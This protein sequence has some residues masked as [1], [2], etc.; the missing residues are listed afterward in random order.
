MKASQALS[1]LVQHPAKVL[2]LPL[3]GFGDGSLK[4]GMQRCPVFVVQ[5]VRLVGQDAADG[6]QVDHLPLGKIG[7][8]VED[9][10][11]VLDV[12]FERH[13]PKCTSPLPPWRRRLSCSA[14]NKWPAKRLAWRS[15]H[16]SPS[17]MPPSTRLVREVARGY[18]SLVTHE[19][20]LARITI[21]PA[22]CHGKPC[23]R[24]QR[25][26]VGLVLGMLEGGMSEEEIL[27]DYPNLE[28]ADIRACLA[29]ASELT[30]VRFVDLPLGVS[31]RPHEVIP[32]S[33]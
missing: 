6:L 27:A 31:T 20:L 32:I 23:I 21:D 14:R 12:G 11:P 13:A 26:W 18:P 10:A 16:P 9:E 7:G 33:P 29:Y 25:I 1:K 28:S 8:L 2:G 15:T 5:V 30:R 17:P 3:I 22:V 24:G 19:E 4:L